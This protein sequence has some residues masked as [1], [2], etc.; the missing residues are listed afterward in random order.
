MPTGRLFG[1]APRFCGAITLQWHFS[2]GTIAMHFLTV[3]ECRDWC[4]ENGVS[5]DADG[6]PSP[7]R[8]GGYHVTSSWSLPPIR[9]I[10]RSSKSSPH[11]SPAL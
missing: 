3:V 5:L 7:P 1:D 11:R 8:F 2:N 9:I 6:R 4:S 10:L